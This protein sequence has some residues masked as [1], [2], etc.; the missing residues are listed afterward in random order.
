MAKG[1]S[2]SIKGIGARAN[3]E[4]A[5]PFLCRASPRQAIGQTGVELLA[6]CE[7][8]QIAWEM[9]TEEGSVLTYF[10][11]QALADPKADRNGDERVSVGE[12][13]HFT[14]RP[15]EDYVRKTFNTS[16]TPTLL[17]N[18]NDSVYLKP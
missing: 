17:D 3:R 10:V 14:K 11:L 8:N 5:E 1:Q 13:F 18:A 6:A 15:I 12:V 2:R 4:A 9:P 7:G 16:Q